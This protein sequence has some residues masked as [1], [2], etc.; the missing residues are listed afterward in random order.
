MVSPIAPFS[1]S[2]GSEPNLQVGAI[3]VAAM[4]QDYPSSS[5]IIFEIESKKGLSPDQIEEGKATCITIAEENVGMP[6]IFMLTSSIQD[7]LQ[8]NNIPGHDG[9]MY[10]GTR[11]SSLSIFFPF[12]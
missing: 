7:W 12:L 4:V 2:N 9:S 10:A 8:E 11:I 5:P 6:I 1:Y 3:L